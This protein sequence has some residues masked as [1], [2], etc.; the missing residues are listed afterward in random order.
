[1]GPYFFQ[2]IAVNVDKGAA[3]FAYQVKM[4]PAG[5]FV[6]HVLIAGAFA[7][8][9]RVLPDRPLR[10]QPFKVPVD[11][12]LPD[13]PIPA[14]KVAGYA[15]YRYVA[16]VQGSYVTE[17]ILPLPGAVVLGTFAHHGPCITKAGESVNM[18][19]VS[20]FILDLSGNSGFNNICLKTLTSFVRGV[21][22]LVEQLNYYSYVQ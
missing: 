6:V 19:I 13:R 8:S 3:A 5:R 22:F 10:R 11:G 16:A 14:G 15:A 4:F 7:V 18:K 1:V 20:I 12:G 2:Q 21:I 17:D 9:Q